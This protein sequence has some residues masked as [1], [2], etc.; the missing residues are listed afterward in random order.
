MEK[1]QMPATSKSA[2]QPG[3]SH[4]SPSTAAGSPGLLVQRLTKYHEVEQAAQ[5]RAMERGAMGS[6]RMTARDAAYLQLREAGSVSAPST[7]VPENKT[8]MPDPLKSGIER[9]SGI[10]MDEV[11]V[12]YNSS[13]PAQLQAHAYAQGTDIHV[14][15]GQERHLPHEAWH[16]VQQAQGRVPPTMQMKGGLPINDDVGLEREA[17]VMGDKALRMKGSEQADTSSKRTSASLQQLKG[18]GSPYSVSSSHEASIQ[19]LMIPQQE[20]DGLTG[21]LDTT[22]LVGAKAQIDRLS[23]KGR[24]DQL[25]AL[26]AML[27]TKKRDHANHPM[28]VKYI[29]ERVTQGPRVPEKSSMGSSERRRVKRSI[30]AGRV[31]PQVAAG[32]DMWVRGDSQRGIGWSVIGKHLRGRLGREDYI[33]IGYIALTKN[34]TYVDGV[35]T[36]DQQVLAGRTTLDDMKTDIR[37]ALDALP[38]FDKTSYRIATCQSPAVYTTTI[39]EGDY[40]KDTTFWSTSAVRGGEAGATGWGVDGTAEIPKVYYIISG[41]S[42]KYIA[43]YSAI[44]GEQEVMFK[45]SVVFQVDRIASFRG[46]SFFVYLTEVNP[47]TLPVGTVMKNPWSGATY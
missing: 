2:P 6:S 1:Q 38:D 37:G 31:D 30:T 34:G 3:R 47:T 43:K 8:G 33:M 46:L 16:V 10:S 18:S 13:K 7:K 22:D 28:L 19:R 45:D 44:E 21:D 40:I 41:S 32:L 24:L 29:R 27:S 42:G 9:L 23:D 36:E 12:H 4:A 20:F 5:R 14:G 11:T 25:K 17:D 35:T 39:S 26:G 15:P